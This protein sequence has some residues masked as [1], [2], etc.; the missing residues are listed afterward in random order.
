MKLISAQ[1]TAILWGISVQMVRR[2]CRE[3]KIPGAEETPFGWMI[4]EG[5][6][7]PGAELIRECPQTPLVKKILYQYERNQHFGI[8]EYI[9]VNLAYSSCRMASNR[10]TRD[11]VIEVYR[12]RKI[13]IAFEP[14]RIDDLVEIS[15]HFICMRYVIANLATPLTVSFLKQLHYL[16]TYSTFADQVHHMGVGEFRTKPHKLGI[17]AKNITKA[18]NDLLKAYERK[19][20]NLE[21]ILDFHV[22]F[23]RIH[24]F[25]D[26]NGRVGRIILMKECLRYGVTSFIIDDKHRGQYNKGI[27]RWDIDPEILKTAVTQSQERFQRKME[28]CN[29][30]Q[31]NRPPKD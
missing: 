25:D 16:L 21:Q 6:L 23:E 27:A 15:N 1:D 18:L 19:A 5:A 12:T 30:M 20:A 28:V 24:P 22:Q 8:Y 11:Q 3:G 17:P 7:K 31:Y 10:L 14:M 4:P 29:L 9:Q 26:Y 2:Y 13:S